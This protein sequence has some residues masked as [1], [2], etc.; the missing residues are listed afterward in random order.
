MKNIR[1]LIIFTICAAMTSC[2]KNFFYLKVL[3]NTNDFDQVLTYIQKNRL[4]ELTDSLKFKDDFSIAINNKCLYENQQQDTVILSFM[5]RYKFDQ[6]CFY[7]NMNSYFDS[8]IIFHKSYNPF[9]GHAI[10]INYDFTES[11]MRE[12]IKA[13]EKFQNRKTRIVNAR[14]IYISN[15]KPAFG[16]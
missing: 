6:I 9:F 13:G 12:K 7:K 1:Y 5:R 15:S 14:Y 16:G 3:N 2:S 4:L 8:V 10:T 11:D